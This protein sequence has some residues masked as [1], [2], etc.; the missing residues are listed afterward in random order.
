MNIKKILQI[1]LTSIL[2]I[3][4]LLSN[5]AI[6]QVGEIKPNPDDLL[7]KFTDPESA[8][9]TTTDYVASLPEEEF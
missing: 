7:Y 3:T 5:T 1:G 6:A 8:E 9:V 2:L 4:T